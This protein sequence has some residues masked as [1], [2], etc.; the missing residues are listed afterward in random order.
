MEFAR[1]DALSSQ[2]VAVVI[3]W[4]ACAECTN[5]VIKNSSD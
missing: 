3:G 1:T 2:T 5:L 4:I